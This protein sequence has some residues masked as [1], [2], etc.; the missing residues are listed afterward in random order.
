MF[1]S[2]VGCGAVTR[3]QNSHDVEHTVRQKPSDFD[4]EQHL[5]KRYSMM[6]FEEEISMSMLHSGTLVLNKVNSGFIKSTA[7]RP[8]Q[9]V[10]S[11]EAQIHIH[12]YTTAFQRRS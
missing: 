1:F 8:V 6:K 4:V 12:Q 10:L 3:S 7:V 9:G 5:G 11:T 2:Y